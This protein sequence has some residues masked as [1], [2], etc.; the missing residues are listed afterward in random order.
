[1]LSSR[2]I[3]AAARADIF[4]RAALEALACGTPAIAAELGGIPEQIRGLRNETSRDAPLNAYGAD[5]AI[6]VLIAAGEVEAMA[7]ANAKDA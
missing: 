4:P 5:D 3:S 7:L 1:M 2:S 6:S